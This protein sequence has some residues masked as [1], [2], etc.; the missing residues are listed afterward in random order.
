M[1][2]TSVVT[3]LTDENLARVAQLGVSSVAIRYPGP[4]RE[5][6]LAIKSR[7]AK[8][9]LSIAAV[10]GELPIQNA[11][12]GTADSAQDLACMKQ[13][14]AN[15]GAAEIGV[16]CYN[17]MPATDWARTSTQTAERGGAW[18]T[19]FRLADVEQAASLHNVS[20]DLDVAPLSAPQLWGNLET[21]LTELLPTAEKEGIALAM[22]PDDPPL[23]A[24]GK[25]AR[26]MNRIDDFERLMRFSASPS[27]GIC[28]CQGTF[29]AMGVDV[30]AAIR[31]LGD[32]IRYVHFRDSRGAADDF[33]ETFHDNGPTD[34][35]A[36]MHAY[37]EIG[38]Q[39]P[40]RPDHVPQLAGEE[41]GDPGY[42]MLARYYAFGYI[43]ALLQA[44]EYG[45]QSRS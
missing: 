38:F 12:L 2:L 21:F 28:F 37:R 22:H 5:D 16:C 27:N 34:M 41:A 7:F 13:L 4:R 11:I 1:Q 10:E 45:L 24:F 25:H 36:A 39:G 44:A 43:R 14:L 29:A 30:P 15:M 6:W 42:T 17:F 9:G 40:I 19:A 32:R 31:T 20:G 3:P 35:V 23:S 33:V 8:F 18:T 26:I